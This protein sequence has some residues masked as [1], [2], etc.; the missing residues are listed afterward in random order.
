MI[1]YT[2]F[3][4]FGVLLYVAVPSLA[5]GPLR[6]LRL[7]Q[8]WILL[9]TAA[10]LV[11][12]Y[13]VVQRLV[14]GVA[15]AEF[16]LVLGYGLLQYVVAVGFLGIRSHARSRPAFYLALGLALAPLLATK[17]VPVLAPAY[18]FGFLGISYI[19]FRSLDVVFN[20]QDGLITALPAG[21]YL[22]FLLF[23]PTISSG[24]I[25]RYRR[26]GRDW[27]HNRSRTEFLNDLDQ[28][29]HHV[30]QGFLYKF[31]LA[32]LIQRY[33][34]NPVA[35]GSQL[36]HVIAYGYVYVFYLFFDFAGYSAFAIGL[37]YLLGVHTP[38]NFNRPFLSHNIR[39]FWE[40]WHISLSIWFR[41]YVYMR[42]VYAA[43]KGKWFANR[44]LASYLGFFLTMGLM[45]LWHGVAWHY[46]IYGLY[47]GG[48]LASHEW[49][50]RWNK[51]H[52]IFGKGRLWQAA[53][54]FGTFNAV[55]FGMLL[56][57]GRLGGW[58]G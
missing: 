2:S 12:Q 1:P 50:S 8:A 5:V 56:F 53:A 52:Q 57:S 7:S 38:E 21:Q 44:Y 33:L 31:I 37:S 26:F 27:T 25:D 24:P 39:E 40:R 45:G 22:A 15:V 32:D 46:L 16:A 23:F 30:F 9:A 54:I 49:F 43:T 36:T 47:H 35:T 4:Y 34:L 11:V 29:V 18:G 55:C 19:T 10:M 42:F 28:A 58:L 3:L 41:D 13:G 48:L 51:A 17:L 6:R 14:G 20:I